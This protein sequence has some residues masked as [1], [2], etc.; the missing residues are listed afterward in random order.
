M[1][2]NKRTS[3]YFDDYNASDNYHEILFR[4]RFAVQTRELNQ[5]QTMFHEQLRRFGDHTFEDGSMVIPGES[6]F[7]LN[8]DYVT[9][10]ITDYES[11]ASQIIPGSTMVRGLSGITANVKL[12]KSPNRPTYFLS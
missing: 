10:T 1:P 6:S 4:P 5:I 12:A 2:V 7:D 3:P 8:L 11:V 9:V